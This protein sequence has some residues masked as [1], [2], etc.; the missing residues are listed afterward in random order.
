MIPTT[1]PGPAICLRGVCIGYDDTL[2]VED[3]DLEVPHGA[4]TVLI[5][6]NGSGKTTLLRGLTRQ[7]PLRTGSMSVLGR[8]TAGWSPR[9]FARTVALLPQSPI[10]PEGMTVEQLVDR[11]R[12]PYR[13]LFGGRRA[14]DT[15]AVAGALER[16]GM[17]EF[18]ERR[19][20]ELSGGQRQ[21]AW[22]ALVLAQSA[23]VMLLDE[24]TSY[25]DLAHQLDLMDLVRSLP[26][27]REPS[28]RAT[29]VMVLHEL[30]L[31]A[32]VAD[33]VVAVR[34]G[35][36]AAQGTPGEVLVPDVL[37]EVFGLDADVTPDPLLG[38]PVVMPRSVADR[39][40]VQFTP[41]ARGGS[42]G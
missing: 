20:T 38:H 26:D 41:L 5:G 3:L 4:T 31:A 18:A 19:L 21:R 10:A 14:D 34:D 9:E 8:D 7:L 30:N 23:P 25:L 1:S 27:P 16:T 12:H 28:R 22:L 42:A 32:R 36:I 13:R 15:D 40:A 39:Q 11:G 29:V 35:R 6:A 2:V 24:P 17:L 33:H 37:S